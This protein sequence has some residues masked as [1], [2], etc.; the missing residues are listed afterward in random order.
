MPQQEHGRRPSSLNRIHPSRH[1]LG[2]RP[3]MQTTV[4]E[5]GRIVIPA[6]FRRAMGIKPGDEVT[7]RLVDGE[8]HVFTQAYATAAARE[9]IRQLVPDGRSL[10]DEIISDRRVEAAHE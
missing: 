10:A 6:E 1:T 4:D 9:W 5:N 2:T 8:V 3:Q 7:V